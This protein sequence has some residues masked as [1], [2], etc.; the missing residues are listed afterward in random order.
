[1]K[2]GSI[3]LALAFAI[4]PFLQA[5]IPLKGGLLF[6]DESYY[7]VPYAKDYLSTLTQSKLASSVSLKPYAPDPKDQGSYNNCVGWA[8]AYAARS[9]MEARKQGWTNRE[10]INKNAFAPGFI[11]KLIAPKQSCYEPT[12]IEH[13]LQVMQKT[14]AAKF[15]AVEQICPKSLSRVAYASASRYKIADYQRLFYYKEPAQQKVMAIK[16]SLADG[17]PVIVGMRCTPSFEHADGYDVWKVRES[18]NTRNYYGHAMCIVAFDDHKYGGAFQI[19]NSW[20]KRWGNK[21]FIW[22]RYSDF[23]NF[24]KYAFIMHPKKETSSTYMSKRN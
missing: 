8:S 18:R 7:Q 12:S 15:S 23:T 11:Y 21:G 14:G 24:V 17:M 3:L 1:M 19:M 20:G 6:D 10:K 9:I 5:Q 22:V 2:R 16:K 13:A 4:S